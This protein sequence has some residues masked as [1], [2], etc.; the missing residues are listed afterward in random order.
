MRHAHEHTALHAGELR[1]SIAIGPD[2][3]VSDATYRASV[4]DELA[5]CVVDVIKKLRFDKPRGGAAA[6]AV[7]PMRFVPGTSEI[8]SGDPLG[9]MR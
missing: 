3:S 5:M 6:K 1:I 9:D 7:Y 2:G 4:S 8:E